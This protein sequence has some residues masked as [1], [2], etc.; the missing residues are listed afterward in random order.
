MNESDLDW[1]QSVESIAY[2]SP[3][4]EK[5]FIKA[6]DDGLSYVFSSREGESLGYACCMAVLD[7]LHLLNFCIAPQF[8][9]RGLGMLAMQALVEKFK[10]SDY[11]VILLEVRASNLVAIHLYQKLGFRIDGKRFN[12][13]PCESGREDAILMSLKLY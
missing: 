10:F 8:Q 11:L 1:V 2:Y 9:R 5:G 7:E 13:Y 12:Y 6:L 3:W 4:S